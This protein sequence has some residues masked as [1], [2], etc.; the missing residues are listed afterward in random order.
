MSNEMIKQHADYAA[1]D[2]DRDPILLLPIWRKT[3]RQP[4]SDAVVMDADTAWSRS[5]PAHKKEFMTTSTLWNPLERRNQTTTYLRY[6]FSRHWIPIAM[7][8]GR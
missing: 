7:L 5:L 1:V 6:V 3:H 4:Q 8:S 2:L